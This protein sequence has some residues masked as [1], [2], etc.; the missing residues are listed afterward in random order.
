[1]ISTEVLSVHRLV[2]SD[3][4][5][6]ADSSTI[7][8]YTERSV[9]SWIDLVIQRVFDREWLTTEFDLAMLLEFIKEHTWLIVHRLV[10]TIYTIQARRIAS[11]STATAKWHR[12]VIDSRL[13]LL[14]FVNQEAN[15]KF[16][17]IVM[18]SILAFML[19]SHQLQLFGILRINFVTF[20]IRDVA[21]VLDPG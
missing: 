3:S 14:R 21:T 6:Q 4:W 2:A 16:T 7:L 5:L 15:A 8:V 9:F 17:R 13:N 19:L 1:M 11:Q 18:L 12:S 20:A 10:T